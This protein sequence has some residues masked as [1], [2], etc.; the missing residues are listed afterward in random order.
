MVL[1]LCIGDLLHCKAVGNKLS[2]LEHF[3]TIWDCDQYFSFASIKIHH[4]EIDNQF[5]SW[6]IYSEMKK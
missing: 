5:R 3:S 2:K 1:K 6:N 4:Q